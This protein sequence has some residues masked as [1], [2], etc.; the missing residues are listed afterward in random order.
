MK[1]LSKKTQRMIYI[2]AMVVYG[3]LMVVLA[4]VVGR[5]L[6]EGFRDP[7]YFD[8]WIRSYGIWGKAVYVGITVLQVIV[9]V[10]PGEPFEIGGGY[11]FGA[12]SGTLLCLMG[13]AIGSILV[14]SLVRKFGRSLVE[15]FFSE[16]QINKL[17]FLH[18][19]R[20]LTLLAF[21]LFCVPGTPKDLLAYVMGLTPIEPLRLFVINLVARIPSVFTST[22]AGY[23]LRKGAFVQTGVVFAITLVISL[24]GL[25]FYNRITKK[26]EAQESGHEQ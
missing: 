13:E 15:V 9:A 22:Y 1:N 26:K 8:Q 23:C 17:S 14:F 4:K 24:T 3:T 5:P 16:E 20:K 19:E 10:I 7:E 25:Y 11:C 21:I 2:A 12:V 18:D 6:V